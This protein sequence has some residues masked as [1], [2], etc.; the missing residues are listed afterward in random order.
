M[1]HGY[2]GGKLG[3]AKLYFEPIRPKFV[4]NLTE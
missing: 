3:F 1:V 2:G 4:V